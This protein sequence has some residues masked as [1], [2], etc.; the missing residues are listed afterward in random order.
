MGYFFPTTKSPVT[1][2][3]S[4]GYLIS[5]VQAGDF[6]DERKCNEIWRSSQLF[7]DLEIRFGV[8][9]P[10]NDEANTF[11]GK[12]EI[13]QRYGRE[14]SGAQLLFKRIGLADIVGAILR[15]I[16]R[17]KT[18]VLDYENHWAKYTEKKARLLVRSKTCLYKQHTS[19]VGMHQRGY[20]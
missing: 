7:T 4:L 11:V 1:K 15:S 16:E 14:L 20:I 17:K 9:V 5:Y 6:S 3:K 12:L 8:V 13:M 2:D 18:T 10:S 19:R